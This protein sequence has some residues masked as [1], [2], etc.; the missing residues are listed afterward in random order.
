[1]NVRTSSWLQA[2]AAGGYL[3]CPREGAAHRGPIGRAVYKGYLWAPEGARGPRLVQHGQKCGGSGGGGV[4]L[5]PRLLELLVLKIYL[6]FSFT[7]KAHGK[8]RLTSWGAEFTDLCG[9]RLLPALLPVRISAL[10]CDL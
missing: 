6:P 5:L 8:L 2:A 1:M 9:C 4:S 7:D 10:T 3:V